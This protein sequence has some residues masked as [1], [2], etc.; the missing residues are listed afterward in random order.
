MPIIT[1][2]TVNNLKSINTMKITIDL[3]TILE[4]IYAESAWY[5][6]YEPT[7]TA[8]SSDN[9]RLLEM[10]IEDGFA[11]LRARIDAYVDHWNF[12]PYLD[13]Q[14]ITLVLN[15]PDKMD[16]QHDSITSL[17]VETLAQWTLM[18]FYNDENAH[19]EAAWRVARARLVMIMARAC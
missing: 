6:A 10:S 5:A 13:D 8:L 17:V 15:L 2:L 14:N 18:R 4:R 19:F 16:L 9:A 12:N 11:D 7:R 3:D 1:F